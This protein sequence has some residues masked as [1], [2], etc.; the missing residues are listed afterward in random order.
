MAWARVVAVEEL[1]S[2][3]IL[4]IVSYHVSVCAYML[5]TAMQ[6]TTTFCGGIWQNCICTCLLISNPYG[7]YLKDTQQHK[8]TYAQVY[9]LQHHLELQNIRNNL[10]AFYRKVVE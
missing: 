3:W 10:N 7:I 5:L 2:G 9:L 4:D 8:T 6:I 1:R